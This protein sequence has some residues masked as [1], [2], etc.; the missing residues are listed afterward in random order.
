MIIII[1]MVVV[2]VVVVETVVIRTSP[3]TLSHNK[4]GNSR[5]AKDACF[6]WSFK[7]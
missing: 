7:T 2:V 6:Q 4:S 3:E 1:M 5:K